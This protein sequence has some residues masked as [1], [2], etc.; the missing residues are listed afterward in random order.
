MQITCLVSWKNCLIIGNHS[1]DLGIVES[2]N[3]Q[4]RSPD[5]SAIKFSKCNVSSSEVCFLQ[6]GAVEYRT[7]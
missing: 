7:H 5:I 1:F 6:T 2:I 4:F 3:Q